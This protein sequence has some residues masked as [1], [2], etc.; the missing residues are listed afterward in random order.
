MGDNEYYESVLRVLTILD[1]HELRALKLD[2]EKWY[3][4]DDVQDKHN[5]EV[6]FAKTPKDKLNL[7][8]KR[9]GGYWRFSELKDFCY[10]V[11][12]YFPTIKMQEEIKAFFYDLASQY[13]SGLST[14]NLLAGKMFG[15]ESENILVGNGAAEIIK[16]IGDVIEGSF[17]MMFTTFNEYPENLS[18]DRIVKFIPDNQSFVYGIDELKLLSDKSDNLILINPD[19]PSGHFNRKEDLIELIDYMKKVISY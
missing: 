13:P 19:N 9:F 10:L 2:C 5:A 18:H 8:Q 1:S 16:V 7:I 14:Q 15:I 11:N 6:I 12:P 3:E 17:G 4:I